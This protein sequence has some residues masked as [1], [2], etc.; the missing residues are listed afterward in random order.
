M[1]HASVHPTLGGRTDALSV[2]LLWMQAEIKSTI[3]IAPVEPVVKKISTSAMDVLCSR[4][5][6]WVAVIRLQHRLNRR[7]RINHRCIGCIM[8]QK[9]C[10]S[11]SVNLFSTGWTDA[12]TEHA[13]VQWR[14]PGYCV[15]TPNGYYLDTER[16]VEPTAST[17]NP[18]VLPVVTI[19]V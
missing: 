4:E 6:V 11:W 14:K 18:S 7:F 10:L 9:A 17:S 15:R 5:H 8:F 13:P 19:F 3:S 1:T 16:P 12:P 2:Y